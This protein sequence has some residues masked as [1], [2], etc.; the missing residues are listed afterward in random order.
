[1][2]E[3]ADINQPLLSEA[4]PEKPKDPKWLELFLK[5]FKSA[6]EKTRVPIKFEAKQVD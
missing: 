1:M 4:V 6:D 3:Q 5:S 2:N